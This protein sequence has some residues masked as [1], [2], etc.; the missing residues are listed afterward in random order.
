MCAKYEGGANCTEVA[1]KKS[2]RLS[3]RLPRWSEQNLI[4][5]LYRRRELLWPGPEQLTQTYSGPALTKVD[6]V[7][8]ADRLPRLGRLQ[9]HTLTI[10]HAQLQRNAFS[11]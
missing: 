4:R 5:A 8:L 2:L 7:A 9:R 10:R 11:D 3:H 6:F 1:N